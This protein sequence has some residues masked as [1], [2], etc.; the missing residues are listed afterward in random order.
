MPNKYK[1]PS[2]PPN[3]KRPKPIQ[4]RNVENE[5]IKAGIA[6][7][8]DTRELS[9]RELKQLRPHVFGK[10]WMRYAPAKPTH[11]R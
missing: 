7:D 4:I 11:R 8:P 6:A 10:R 5:R 1:V 2:R 9:R 3:K